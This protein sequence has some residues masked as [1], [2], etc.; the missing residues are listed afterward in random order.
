MEKWKGVSARARALAETARRNAE[1]GEARGAL[2]QAFRALGEA[3]YAKDTL[4]AAELVNRIDGMKARVESLL[5]ELDALRDERRCPRCGAVQRKEHRFCVQCG[6]ALETHE[7][8][9][10]PSLANTLLKETPMLTV[11]PSSSRTERRICSAIFIA[12]PQTARLPVT[13]SQHSSI[14]KGSTM[15]VY[16]YS[17]SEQ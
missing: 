13:S 17:L 5:C 14:P 4:R 3:Y 16:E 9:I 7:A 1:L 11:R 12:S 10:D 15:S 2:A 8:M 6:A